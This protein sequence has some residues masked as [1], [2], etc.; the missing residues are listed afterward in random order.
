MEDLLKY[1]NKIKSIDYDNGLR[2][3]MNY[4]EVVFE[5]GEVYENPKFPGPVQTLTIDFGD[6]VF[7]IVG[8][9]TWKK[10]RTE[11]RRHA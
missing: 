3:Y 7:E 8:K 2:K 1:K 6:C 4:D 9:A 10:K 11:R 5:N